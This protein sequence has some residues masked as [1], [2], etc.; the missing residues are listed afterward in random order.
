MKSSGPGLRDAIE[1]SFQA[2]ESLSGETRD[3]ATGRKRSETGATTTRREPSL[4][5]RKESPRRMRVTVEQ[6]WS[7]MASKLI[8]KSRSTR[9]PLAP[10][11]PTDVADT[12]LA[13]AH[14]PASLLRLDSPISSTSLPPSHLTTPKTK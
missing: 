1:L 14:P 4:A 2:R 6:P 3:G 12:I 7:S 10:Q 8:L 13:K 5:A 9:P 11:K